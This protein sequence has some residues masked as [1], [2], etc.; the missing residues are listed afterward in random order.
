MVAGIIVTHGDLSAELCRTARMIYGEIS[1]VYAI[2]NATLSDQEI[3]KRLESILA[4]NEGE[5]H[6][7]F[8]DFLGGGCGR[9]CL[10]FKDD[11]DGIPM[12]SGVNLPMILAFLNKREEVPFEKLPDEL[13]SRGRNSIKI[14]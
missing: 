4:E 9:I 2:S 5:A 13:I 14:L 8:V 10:E 7:I 3:K 1:K 6:I 11:H 12:I